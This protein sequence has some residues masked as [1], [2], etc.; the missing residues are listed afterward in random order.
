MG[1]ESSS[2]FGPVKPLMPALRSGVG[3][4]IQPDFVVWRDL[5]DGR[6][7]ALMPELLQNL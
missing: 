6:L 2:P 7:E 3:L 1:T 5:K 4:A